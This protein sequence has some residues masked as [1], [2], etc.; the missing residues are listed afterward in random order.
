[1]KNIF[2]YADQ[3]KITFNYEATV[4][5][6]HSLFE[7]NDLIF[8]RACTQSSRK[9]PW[10]GTCPGSFKGILITTTVWFD[11]YPGFRLLYLLLDKMQASRDDPMPRSLEGIRQE[12]KASHKTAERNQ[13]CENR[14]TF[15]ER[16][17]AVRCS[18]VSVR[19][20]LLC[21]P[22]YSYCTYGALLAFLYIISK[23]FFFSLT[24]M[25]VYPR[26]HEIRR[27]LVWLCWS[28]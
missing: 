22:T 28:G 24:I 5:Y 19:T 12:Q 7:T 8:K 23:L 14:K 15:S 21:N 6:I 3:I 2:S 18:Q 11:I 17:P 20:D 9:S 10:F 16:F 26:F 1:M 13:K 25:L 27:C 4:Q